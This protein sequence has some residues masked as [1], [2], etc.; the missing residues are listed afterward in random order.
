MLLNFTRGLV[1]VVAA[2]VA[3]VAA[4]ADLE[5]HFDFDVGEAHCGFGCSSCCVFVVS[6]W[7]SFGPADSFQAADVPCFGCAWRSFVLHFLEPESKEKIKSN[8]NKVNS[9]LLRKLQTKPQQKV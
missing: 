7:S 5:D 6:Q 1:V 8:R 3:V 4:A 9:L 2:V